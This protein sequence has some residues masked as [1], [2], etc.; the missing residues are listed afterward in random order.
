MSMLDIFNTDPFRVI[1][2][3]QAIQNVKF[4]PGR[5]GQLGIFS[6]SSIPTT[7]LALEERGGILML[8]PP[9]P[10]G[11][12]GTTVDKIKRTMRSVTVPHFQIDDGMMAEEV[13]GVRAFGNETAT[14][15]LMDKV[16]E[17]AEIARQ[18]FEA[19]H[20]F[21]RVG[22][23]KGVI[24]YADG[25]TLDL[26]NLFGVSQIAEID[27]DL[28]NAN[29]APGALR[30]V[31][32]GLVRTIT[33]ELGG[34][35]YTGIRAVC[36]NNFFDNLINHKEVI[37]TYLNWL[38]AEELRKSYVNIGGGQESK[39]YGGFQ[40]ADITWENYRG[41]V[42]A[43]K[44]VDDDKVH[45]FLDGVP[46]L[47]RTVYAPADYIETVNTMGRPIYAKQ[48]RMENDKGISMEWQT[49]AIHFCTRPR[50]LL[51][52]KRT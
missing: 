49:N 34:L 32:A 51:K 21:A 36:G 33:D 15:I 17:R 24:T 40:W 13:Q 23:V 25:T 19:T 35:P 5:I 27:F 38:A 20:E 9:T 1:P 10:R 18:S 28:D 26:F 30:Q 16:A 31:C 43:T 29:P 44:F 48:W 12:P 14:E 6:E 8:V 47:F 39:I 3:S 46:G 37:A 11:G 41:S 4:V 22:A 45:F 50:T 2:L 42:G 52:G 7:S